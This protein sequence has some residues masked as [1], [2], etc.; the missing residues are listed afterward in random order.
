MTDWTLADAYELLAVAQTF[1]RRTVGDFDAGGWRRAL[2]GLDLDDAKQAVVEHYTTSTD[3][4][5]P[6]HVRAGVK[7]LRANRLE[8]APYTVPDADP[9]DPRAFIAALKAGTT[10]AA[11]GEQPRDLRQLEQ[12][13]PAVP[14]GQGAPPPGIA[15]QVR[16]LG[17][18]RRPHLTHA[19]AMADLDRLATATHQPEPTDPERQEASQ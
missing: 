2:T 1:D 16:A 4:L 14:P 9:D 3:W 15:R 8:R 12:V 7:R 18:G 6:G 10:L 13:F 19:Q 11:G 5:M 17:P